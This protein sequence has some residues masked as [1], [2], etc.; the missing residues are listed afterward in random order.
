MHKVPLVVKVGLLALN[1]ITQVRLVWQV[2]P[3]V[4]STQLCWQ[5]PPTRRGLRTEAAH[6]CS[7]DEQ[8]G[9]KTKGMTADVR[10]SVICRSAF[11]AD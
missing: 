11:A 3:S 9:V 6:C 1:P 4:C 5:G 8:C 7:A 10:P 2:R